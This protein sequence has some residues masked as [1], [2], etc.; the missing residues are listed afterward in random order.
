[1]WVHCV[2]YCC[3]LNIGWKLQC[4]TRFICC[5]LMTSETKLFMTRWQSI[6]SFILTQFILIA[7]V[8]GHGADS[9]N[10]SVNS[11]ANSKNTSKH[12]S[13]DFNAGNNNVAAAAA[14]V[15][16]TPHNSS[17]HTPHPSHTPLSHNNTGHGTVS[18]TSTGGIAID[19]VS[20]YDDDE[21]EDD[22]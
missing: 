11:G 2:M 9:S 6:V 21:D 20:D 22:D 1:M 12:N 7:V 18:H 3:V 4:E 8:N 17:I 16:H 13:G 10:V 19:D 5:S 14:A 15:S